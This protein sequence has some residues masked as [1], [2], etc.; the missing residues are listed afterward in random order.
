LASFEKDYTGKYGQQNIKFGNHNYLFLHIAV[1]IMRTTN[2]ERHCILPTHTYL[3]V[4]CD[5][6]NRHNSI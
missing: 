5:R 6:T 1:V 3:C 4:L 2:V